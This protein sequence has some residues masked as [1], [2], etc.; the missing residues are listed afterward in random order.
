MMNKNVDK[1]LSLNV[2][3]MEKNKQ[4]KAENIRLKSS[5]VHTKFSTYKMVELQ[6]VVSN[7]AQRLHYLEQ[8]NSEG[9]TDHDP[10]QKGMNY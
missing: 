10:S 5:K 3:L 6:S 8:R 1:L 4:L 7:M 2:G 9:H